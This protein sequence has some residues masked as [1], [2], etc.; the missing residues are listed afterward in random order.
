MLLQN[1]VTVKSCICHDLAGVATKPRGIDRLATPSICCGPNIAYFRREASLD[2]M[3][4]HIY[5]R[6]DLLQGVRSDVNLA[7]LGLLRRLSIEIPFPQRVVRQ[8]APG[9]SVAPG[10]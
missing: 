9:G 6:G 2:E 10:R 4:G 3:I 8:I 5:G 7:I 1:A